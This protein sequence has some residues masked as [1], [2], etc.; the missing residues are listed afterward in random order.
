M[1]RVGGLTYTCDPNAQDG[2]AASA[3]CVLRTA[4]RLE[5]GQDLQGGRL[6]GGERKTAKDGGGRAD[7][8]T[9]GA[10]SARAENDPATR[11]ECT[12]AGRRH[13]Q[14]RHRPV[15]RG[16]RRTRRGRA[17]L[18]RDRHQALERE[19][20]HDRVPRLHQHPRE[21]PLRGKDLCRK[22]FTMLFG[23]SVGVMLPGLSEGAARGV[24]HRDFGAGTD[25]KAGEMS[26]E[27]E[28]R[29]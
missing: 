24:D 8:G 26:H 20:T 23:E 7:L 17:K 12:Q 2:G 28:V 18:P 5:A 10:L 14:S 6:G 16:R 27:R 13:R 29:S 15:G 9:D 3:T 1:V 11:L 22:A 19:I 4:S 25:R 21:R